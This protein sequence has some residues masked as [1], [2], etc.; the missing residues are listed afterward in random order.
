MK[1]S[2]GCR[3]ITIIP[4]SAVPQRQ[5]RSDELLCEIGGSGSRSGTALVCIFGKLTF[6][7]QIRLSG[8]DIVFA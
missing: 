6:Q 7:E 3:D 1:T 8:V 4:V 2:I 5:A